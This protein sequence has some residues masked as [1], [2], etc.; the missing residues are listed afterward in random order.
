M[1]LDFSFAACLSPSLLHKN[2]PL[3]TKT[4]S[5]YFS[6]RKVFTRLYLSRKVTYRIVRNMHVQKVRWESDHWIQKNM[7]TAGKSTSK[8]NNTLVLD[9]H[10]ILLALNSHF[11]LNV[12]CYPTAT[13]IIL[14][15]NNITLTCQTQSKKRR[16]TGPCPLYLF[17]DKPTLTHRSANGWPPRSHS[18]SISPSNL[19]KITGN[20]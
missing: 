18:L 11:P 8:E 14:Y 1:V 10:L 19:Y 9:N 7:E 15:Y 16:K 17:V 6:T 20:G 2:V 13:I 3:T 4:L 5:S 12:A